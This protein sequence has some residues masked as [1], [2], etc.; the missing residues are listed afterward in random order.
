MYIMLN[1]FVAYVSSSIGPSPACPRARDNAAVGE[2]TL[3]ELAAPVAREP[4]TAPA[5]SVH[6][7]TVPDLPRSVDLLDP[8]DEAAVPRGSG[9]MPSSRFGTLATSRSTNARNRRGWW[10]ARA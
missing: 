5:R 1:L 2:T 4:M 6:A 7:T 9:L 10:R 8:H 3:R